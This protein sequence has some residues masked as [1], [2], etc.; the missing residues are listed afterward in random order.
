MPAKLRVTQTKSTISHT[1]GP[2]LL[3]RL[4][5]PLNKPP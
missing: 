3:S 2:L 4:F 5:P 1:G